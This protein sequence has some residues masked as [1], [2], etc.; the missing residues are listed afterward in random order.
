ML[1]LW[2]GLAA[3]TLI[4]PLTWEPPHAMGVALKRQK[5]F[6]KFLLK[7]DIQKYIQKRQFLFYYKDCLEY[8]DGSKPK[9]LKDGL[10]HR[11][12]LGAPD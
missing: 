4:Q 7:N 1:W 9:R 2:C 12:K 11:P 6:I 3:V 5:K 8:G 10:P